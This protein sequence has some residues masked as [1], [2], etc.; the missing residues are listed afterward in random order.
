[1]R[2]RAF[3]SSLL[4]GLSSL[5]GRGAKDRKGK[6]VAAPIQVAPFRGGRG[7]RVCS[8][9][10]L[11]SGVCT[12]GWSQPR[13]MAAVALR[14][15]RKRSLEH[16]PEKHTLTNARGGRRFQRGPHS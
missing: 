9:E 4:S 3:R 5:N 7:L 2:V 11:H 12:L 15:T 16:V 8:P 6:A 1:R 14:I 10:P 13:T